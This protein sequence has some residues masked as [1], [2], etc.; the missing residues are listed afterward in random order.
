MVIIYKDSSAYKPDRNQK[1][2][3]FYSSK[4]ELIL[5]EENNLLQSLGK[6]TIDYR[7]IDYRHPPFGV[8]D[9]FEDYD[10]WKGDYFVARFGHELSDKK[11]HSKNYD[12]IYD[13][14]GENMWPNKQTYYYYDDKVRQYEL[15]KKYDRHIPSVICNNLDEL[16]NDVSVGTVVKSTYGAGGSSCFY[17]WEKEHLNHIEEYISNSY[18]SEKFFPCIIQEYI[19]YDWEYIIF[20]TGDEIYGYKKNILKKYSSPN[21]FPYNFPI[22]GSW[23]QF[24]YLKPVDDGRSWGEPYDPEHIVLDEKELNPDLIQFILNI[25]NELNTPNLKFDMINGKVFEFSYLYP[26]SMAMI[27]SSDLLYTVYNSEFNSFGEK[28]RHDLYSWKHL[29]H[30]AVLKHLGII[31]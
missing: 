4:F 24:K 3:S 14:Y 22:E 16:L 2:L 30:R 6:K 20:S 10:D 9:N 11:Y 7:I 18:N 29:Q 23:D 15:L 26:D 21:S 31:K 1:L 19:D 12:V 25:K 8:S 28:E 13:Y 5:K 17:I 27:P